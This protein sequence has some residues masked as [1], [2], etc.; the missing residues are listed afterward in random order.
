VTKK[1]EYYLFFL[2]NGNGNS[3][4]RQLQII[5]IGLGRLKSCH[6]QLSLYLLPYSLE[7]NPIEPSSAIVKSKV[8]QV[9]LMEE[10]SLSSRVAEIC[11]LVAH[12]D[13]CGFAR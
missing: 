8:R 4:R 11:N 1:K 7:R 10:E 3:W 12:E 6:Q 5:C 9:N 13:L 2:V